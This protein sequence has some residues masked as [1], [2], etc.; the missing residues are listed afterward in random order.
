MYNSAFHNYPKRSAVA[1]LGFPFILFHSQ[2]VPVSSN[3]VEFSQR[4]QITLD[5]IFIFDSVMLGCFPVPPDCP[6]IQ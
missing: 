6:E 4:A 3:G 1:L 5:D 2:V